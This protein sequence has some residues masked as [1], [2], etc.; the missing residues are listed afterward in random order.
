M[1][2]NADTD[3]PTPGEYAEEIEEPSTEKEPGHEP[4]DPKQ[5]DPQ[6]SHQAVGIGVVGG[7]QTKEEPSAES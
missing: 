1:S 6:P 3:R 7:P 5:D 4:K 2:E